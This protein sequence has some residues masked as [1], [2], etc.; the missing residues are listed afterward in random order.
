MRRV[1]LFTLLA[2][3]LP[4]AAL[5]NSSDPITINFSIVPI[6]G[7]PSY[8]GGTLQSSSAFNFG[9]GQFLVSGLGMGDQSGLNPG[10]PV[11]LSPTEITY[12][13]GPSGNLATPLTKTW[14]DTLGTFSETLTSFTADRTGAN[15]NAIDMVLSGVVTTPGG[16]TEPITA[17]LSANQD[18]GPGKAV[19]WSLTELATG[20]TPVPEPGTLGLL[21]LGLLGNGVLGLAGI[22]RRKLKLG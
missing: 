11:T 5:A 4:T 14:T 8:T 9:S 6:G 15:V 3:A 19:G 17:T 7:N 12:G 16:T 20:V 21:E 18:G 13:S 2:L 1:M 22:G 10:D